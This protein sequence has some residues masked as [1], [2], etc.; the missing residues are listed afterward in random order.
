LYKS[1][2]IS[3]FSHDDVC[4]VIIYRKRCDRENGVCVGCSSWVG[5]LSPQIHF[6]GRGSAVSS[7]SSV[8][9]RAPAKIELILHNFRVLLTIRK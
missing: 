4:F 5:I 1:Y 2:L 9:G 3:C 7:P 6:G 8:R